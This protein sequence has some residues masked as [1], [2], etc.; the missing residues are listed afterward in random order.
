MKRCEHAT[1][2]PNMR[3][4][5]IAVAALT[6]SAQAQTLAAPDG[7]TT[8]EQVVAAA[9]ATNGAARLCGASQPDLLQH[10]SNWQ[11]NLKRYAQEYR[12]DT[13]ALKARFTQG[14]ETGRQMMEQMRQASVDGC[15]GVLG[16]F[17]RERAI[18][19][20]EMKQAI[21]EVTDGLPQAPAR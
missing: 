20:G 19:Y 2:D 7:Q 8:F 17:Q 12:Y 18:G 3:A 10:E 21:A 11:V 16:S 13:A 5:W 9:G 14:Q 1:E 15:A 4:L 6:S